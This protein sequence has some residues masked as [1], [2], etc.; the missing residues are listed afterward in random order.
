MRLTILQR[1]LAIALP[2]LLISNGVAGQSS[3]VVPLLECVLY[4]AAT[5]SLSAI[6]GYVSTGDT[7]VQIDVGPNNFFTP[8]VLFR[9]QPSMF[10]PGLH[11]AAFIATFAAD[12][13][14]EQIT[15][16]LNG[17]T[18]T[19]KNEPSLYCG[20]GP[21]SAWRGA[22][23]PVASYVRGDVVSAGGSSW[24]ALQPSSGATP[25][26]GSLWSLVAAGGESG[27]PGPRGEPGPAGPQGEP[28]A[29][30]MLP[31]SQVLR[32]P[33]TGRLRISD[34]NVTA[35]SII[36]LQYTGGHVSSPTAIE[37]DTG[38]FTAVGMPR[39]R[40]RYVVIH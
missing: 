28:G 8:G 34:S 20:A 19:A 13:S 32:F 15:W 16:F 12:G 30:S 27:G 33:R 40:F 17:N 37:I 9:N 23:N 2:V 22:W 7:P 18:A 3:E 29:S 35:T 4:D 21:M 38:L 11:A 24:I 1:A 31:A 14:T 10:Q 36:L 6:F 25:S 5:D 39:R 26:E